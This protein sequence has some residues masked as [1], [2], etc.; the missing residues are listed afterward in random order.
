MLATLALGGKRFPLAP[1]L[2]ILIAA[3]SA[4]LSQNAILLYLTGEAFERHLKG[5]PWSLRD[6]SHWLL[7]P[8]ATVSATLLV[9]VGAIDGAIRARL[10]RYLGLPATVRTGGRIHR[11]LATHAC[12]LTIAPRAVSPL[13]SAFG[14]TR[15]ATTRGIGEP[16]TL[17]KFLL[18][19]REHKFLLAIA[20]HQQ[21]ISKHLRCSHFLG[22]V[23]RRSVA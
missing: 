14:T 4:R 15:R 3:A 7:P 21:T 12:M 1:P 23:P 5:L 19:C 2:R 8:G 22:S 16:S 11:A 10:K 17:I 18:P 6:R 9:T 13:A 20:A